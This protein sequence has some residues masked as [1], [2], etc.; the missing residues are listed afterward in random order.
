MT[1]KDIGL[2]ITSP[3][4]YG[5][6]TYVPDQ[7]LRNWF[8]GGSPNVDYDTSKQISHNGK[9]TFIKELEKVWYMCS[10]IATQNAIL[11]IRFGAINDR[12]VDPRKIILN[13]LKNTPWRVIEISNSGIP[14]KE[15]RQANFF[16]AKKLPKDQ[17]EEIDVI[18]SL[19]L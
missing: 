3:P 6:R 5:M 7:W 2:I 15:R 17:I 14:P 4:Y 9:E 8:V 16:S 19:N 12:V 1:N 18:A 13:S 11:A 10:R